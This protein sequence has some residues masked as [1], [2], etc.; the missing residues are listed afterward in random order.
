MN[1][2]LLIM[3][4]LFGVLVISS[5]IIVFRNLQPGNYFSHPMWLGMNK[6]LLYNLCVLQLLAAIGFV[7]A[8][9]GW[10]RDSP[11][12]GLFGDYPMLLPMTV[13]IL[14]CA[15]A[16]WAP[17]T[18]FRIPW[19]VVG[20]LIATAVA[21]IMLLAGAAEETTQRWWI[22]LGF[23][24]FSTVTVLGDGVI[25]NAMY[26]RQLKNAHNCVE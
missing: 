13:T 26:I 22:V 16:T 11:T 18:F 7:V 24:L 15:S 6:T 9:S 14:L 10:I 17:A 3:T 25:W 1:I 23:L 2:L 20:G 5:Y 4:I 19:L 8:I 21:S 12:S